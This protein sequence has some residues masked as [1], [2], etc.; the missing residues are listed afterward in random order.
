MQ[1]IDVRDLACLVA[2]LIEKDQPGAYNAAGP[3]PAVTLGELIRVCGGFDLAPVTD[4]VDWP[5]LLP[6]ADV[7]RHAPDQRRGRTCRRDA[8]K[9]PGSN[10]G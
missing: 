3:S 5:L 6:D 8:A 1:V 7:G 2:I 4:D 10:R 9:P